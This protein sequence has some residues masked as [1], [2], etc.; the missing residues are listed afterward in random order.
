M[1]TIWK[2]FGV[3]APV[4]PDKRLIGRI[5][6]LVQYRNEIAHGRTSAEDVGR[7]FTVKEIGKRIK[8]TKFICLYLI[9]ILEVHCS[10]SS[11]FKI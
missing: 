7:R 2:L 5:S 9:K 1:E 6:E 8:D 10:T 11:N 4:V 3:T